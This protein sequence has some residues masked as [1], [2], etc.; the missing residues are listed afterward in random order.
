[1]NKEK[2]ELYCQNPQCNKRISEK[3]KKVANL[4]GDLVHANNLCIQ[5]YVCHKTLNSKEI[6][7]YPSIPY[8]PYSEA[9]KLARKGK[10][11]FSKLE[12]TIK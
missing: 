2:I 9:E 11:K 8:I 10:V 7:F 6:V 3:T 12:G 1:M 5:L 4:D